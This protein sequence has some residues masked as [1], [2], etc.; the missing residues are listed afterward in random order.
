MLFEI[1]HFRKRCIFRF[2][3]LRFRRFIHNEKIV[4]ARKREKTNK[5]MR[6]LEK[7]KQKNEIVV[8]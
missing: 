2:R 6:L 5:K 7:T 4:F 1:R 8:L 3:F